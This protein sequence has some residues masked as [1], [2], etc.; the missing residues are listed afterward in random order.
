MRKVLFVCLGNICRSP[1]AE[2]IF[3]AMINRQG[4]ERVISCDSAG[5]SGYH[6]GDLADKRMRETAEKRG[7]KLT[8]RSRQIDLHDF[9]EFD[10]IL[11]ADESNKRNVLSLPGVK[12]GQ[13]FKILDFSLENKGEDVPDPYYGGDKGFDLVLNLLEESLKNFL[14][15]VKKEIA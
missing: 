8:S 9:N 1:A 13:V 12:E 3:E 6:Q 7:Y 2:G 14:S 11:V 4:L 5:T 15:K 10:Y